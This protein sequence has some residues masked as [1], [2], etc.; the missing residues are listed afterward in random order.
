MAMMRLNAMGDEY[1]SQGKN[2]RLDPAIPE[3]TLCEEVKF[4]KVQLGASSLE[5]APGLKS[6]AGG[7]EDAHRRR[8]VQ[9]REEPT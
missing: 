9:L 6:L 4:K 7:L 8:R 5:P 3:T 1:Q 2:E